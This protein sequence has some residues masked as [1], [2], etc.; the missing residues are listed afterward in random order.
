MISANFGRD[1]AGNFTSPNDFH[2]DFFLLDKSNVMN[3]DELSTAWAGRVF[4]V[5]K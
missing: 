3:D 4:A 2:L 1:L 5:L